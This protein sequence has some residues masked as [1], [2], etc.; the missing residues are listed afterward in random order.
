MTMS[1]I[2]EMM[3]PEQRAAVLTGRIVPLPN[4]AGCPLSDGRMMRVGERWS[5]S[6]GHE[7]SLLDV[8]GRTGRNG[9]GEPFPQFITSK[10]ERL[11]FDAVVSGD[12]SKWVRVGQ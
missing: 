8:E 10:Y 7:H 2:Y 1:S 5:Y 4:V 11:G 12:P 9:K 3:T 6:G